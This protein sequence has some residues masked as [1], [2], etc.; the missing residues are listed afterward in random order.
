MRGL[1]KLPVTFTAAG[2]CTATLVAGS[3]KGVCSS[4]SACTKTMTITV[5]AVT[6][7]KW[8]WI[9]PTSLDNI[10][11]AAGP[12][13]GAAGKR[14]FL[15]VGVRGVSNTGAEIALDQCTTCTLTVTSSCT[16]A[17]TISGNGAF[18]NGT[19]TVQV[20]WA[21]A[22]ATAYTCA[23][24]VKVENSG[25]ALEAPTTGPAAAPSVTVCKPA[26]LVMVTNT[27]K[28]FKGAVLPTGVA[29]PFQARVVDANGLHCRG[30]SQ[31]DATVLSVDTDST[32][33][34]AVNV[35]LT[36]SIVLKA[37]AT[38]APLPPRPLND[39]EQLPFAF[40]LEVVQPTKAKNSMRCIGGDFA[41][42]L[43]F[44]NATKTGVR[45]KIT[46]ATLKSTVTSGPVMTMIVA[47]M[48]R[49]DPTN[50]E[51]PRYA[52]YKRE[53]RLLNRTN[54]TVQAVDALDPAWATPDFGLLA[55][56]P[57][58]A[59]DVTMPGNDLGVQW[60]V[61]PPVDGTFPLTFTQG[62]AIDKLTAGQAVFA[63][64]SWSGVDG[65]FALSVVPLNAPHV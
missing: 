21:D 51:P 35:N 25:S 4:V 36:E 27:S 60:M 49:F 32:L 11:D 62:R 20:T 24:S 12:M 46:S 28:A 18:I 22:G 47:S 3:G 48:L 13:Y 64:V 50:A 39:T 30:D 16:N 17:P 45:V 8:F 29:Y 6:A 10:G 42:G 52:V 7:S 57:N 14:S 44:S 2:T 1:A 34:K 53:M 43:M 19:G 26:R 9:T 58:V 56:A 41:F 59:R 65:T 54:F 33:V 31:D 15:T 55:R 63:G 61:T 23:L 5:T 40:I 38:S 37:A